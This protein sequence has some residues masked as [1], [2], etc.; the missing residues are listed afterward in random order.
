MSSYFEGWYFKHQKERQTLAVIAGRADDGA[1]V[2]IITQDGS[3]HVS[4]PLSDYHRGKSL[5]IS[6]NEFSSEGILLCIHHKNIELNGCLRYDHL[7]PI[8]K[9]IMGP[10]RFFPMQCRHTVISMNH[11]LT[12]SIRLNGKDMD[13]TGG[14]GYI[15]GDSGRSFPKS[16]TWVQCNHFDQDCSMMASAAQ[17]PFGFCRFW[18]CICVVC[19]D[20]TEYRLA[21]Y[22]G[23]KIQYRDER[24]LVLTQKDLTLS[25]LFL[26]PHD[27]FSL[28]APT[29]GKMARSIR[30]VPDAPAY[31]EFRQGDRILF[32]GKSLSASCEHVF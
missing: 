7:T 12:G 8:S 16:Y 24:K 2:Q 25:V 10:F 9:D 1:F 32:Q 28:T 6:D 17:I 29:K 11:Q 22:H 18:G 26:Q 5:R 15:E 13:F 23:A 31:F 21:T 3:Y 30:E 14:K 19:I 4:Y 27:G 20:R